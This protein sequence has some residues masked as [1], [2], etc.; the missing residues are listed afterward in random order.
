MPCRDYPYAALEKLDR[1]HRDLT[2]CGHAIDRYRVERR[3][4]IVGDALSTSSRPLRVML[5]DDHQTLLQGLRSLFRS[6]PGVDIVH[7]A[8]DGDAAIMAVRDKAPDL[9]V[10]DLSMPGSNGFAVMRRLRDSRRQTRVIVLTRHSEAGYIR[11][12][13]A[14]GAYAYVLKQ[15]SFAELQLAVESVLAGRRHL[16]AA[17]LS[18]EPAV[19]WSISAPSATARELDILRR[20]ALGDSNKEIAHTLEIA[21]KTVE[22]HKANAM[23]KLGLESR[24]QLIRYAALHGWFEDA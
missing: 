12:A 6:M 10:I 9:L 17:L 5:A 19:Q 1:D 22:A 18:S 20:S 16:D 4:P 24:R 14:A 3:T 7:E 13:F 15:S 21:V 2:E 23:R 8:S 11:E